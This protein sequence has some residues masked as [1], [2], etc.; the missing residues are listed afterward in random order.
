MNTKA[1]EPPGWYGKM[2]SLGDF[3]SRRLPADFITIWDRWLQEVISLSRSDLG[4]AWLD[5]Y[6]T[7]PV[8]RFLLQAGAC[9]EKIWAGV[10]MP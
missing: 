6:L 7:C 8:W 5:A 2:A 10:L 9:G 1:C 3:A 4:D